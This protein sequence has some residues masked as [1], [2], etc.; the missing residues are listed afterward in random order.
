MLRRIVLMAFSL[1]LLCAPLAH[2]ASIFLPDDALNVLFAVAVDPSGDPEAFSVINLNGTAPGTVIDSVTSTALGTATA[3][4]AANIIN[5]TTLTPGDVAISFLFDSAV[6]GE[7]SLTLN[8]TG[9]AVLLDSV[10]A[11]F[12]GE[13]VATFSLVNTFVDEQLNTVRLY[14]LTQIVGPTDVTPI[15]E[16]ASLTLLGIG[17]AAA[18]RRRKMRK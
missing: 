17:L 18:A 12:V 8:G 6:F 2:A 10:L 11:G 1:S 9:S 16:P 4:A 14:E 3:T 7:T 13:D 5:L 15:P